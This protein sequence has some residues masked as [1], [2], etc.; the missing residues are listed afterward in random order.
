MQTIARANRVF[1]NKDNGLI[2]DYVGV[3]R[4]LR[5]SAV[6]TTGHAGQRHDDDN[7]GADLADAP[8][9]GVSGRPRE[10]IGQ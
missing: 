3:F 9:Q 10:S 4:N 7:Q 5:W 2:V 6:L 8:N 1:P